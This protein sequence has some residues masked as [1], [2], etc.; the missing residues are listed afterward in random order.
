MTFA[1]A[2]LAEGYKQYPESEC[3]YKCDVF[4]RL[5]TYINDPDGIGDTST[6]SYRLYN[7]MESDYDEFMDEKTFTIN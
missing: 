1:D 2:L 7:H 3:L 6:W 4:G 5:H